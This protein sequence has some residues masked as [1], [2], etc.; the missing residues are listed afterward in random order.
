MSEYFR[1]T[2]IADGV[3]FSCVRDEKFKHNS[4][5]INLIVPLDMRTAAAYAVLPGILRK[6]SASCPDFTKLE[7]TLCELYGASLS[8][9]VSKHGEYQILGCSI[10]GIDDR[11]ALAGEK[12]SERCAELLTDMVLCP[13]ITDG[14]FPQKDFELEKQYLI[15][16][17]EAEINEKRAYALNRCRTEMCR[18][19]RLA[20]PKYGTIESAEKLTAR[21]AAE[22][23]RELINTARIEII[24]VGSGDPEPVCE[25]MRMRFG[26]LRRSPVSHT[27]EP[28]VQSAET[29]R[30]VTERLEVV[31]S[32]LAMGMRAGD[33]STPEKQTASRLMTYLY[34]GSPFSMLFR[35]VREKLSLCYY[36][37]ARL[38]PA[39]GILMVDM[40]LEGENMERSREAI[41]SELQGIA[42][43]DFTGEDLHSAKLA[44]CNALKS[45]GDSQAS[46]ENWCMTRILQGN[47]YAPSDEAAAIEA[48]TS[49]EII[50]AAGG[51]TLDTVYFLT[52]KEEPEN[53]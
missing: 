34:G 32:K 7:R 6:G 40:G 26:S 51:V 30:T 16:S 29:V 36:C 9:D 2:Q 43:G 10:I 41:W 39:T 37:A 1:R 45:I 14:A 33:L 12:I 31:Q 22:S 50:A 53:A 18:G 5:T 20:V 11:F 49:E 42:G 24:F 21:S 8:A 38:D 17:I 28:L 13:N 15:D 25:R 4:I 23:Y 35:N 19:S 46:V 48:V 52:G 47:N 3:C 27:P 44:Y